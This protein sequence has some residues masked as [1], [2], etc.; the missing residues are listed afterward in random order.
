MESGRPVRI[1]WHKTAV[2]IRWQVAEL[3]RNGQKL[4][5]FGAYHKDRHERTS[6]LLTDKYIK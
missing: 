4:D 5:R 1:L 3:D 2:W 6:G